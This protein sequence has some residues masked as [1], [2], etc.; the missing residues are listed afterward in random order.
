MKNSLEF[1]PIIEQAEVRIGEL[2]DRSVE[3][4]RSKKQK[5][6]ECRKMN[7]ASRPVGNQ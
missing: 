2:E 7:R 6:K 4:I 5:Q 3:I 1:S